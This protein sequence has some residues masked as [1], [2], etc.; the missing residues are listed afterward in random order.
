MTSAARTR[1]RAIT[2]GVI[3]LALLPCVLS[4]V[5]WKLVPIGTGGIDLPPG[6]RL[7]DRSRL[8]FGMLDGATGMD[9]RGD[10][11]ALGRL[12]AALRAD[13]QAEPGGDPISFIATAPD[14]PAW[15][16]ADLDD[17]PE[18]HGWTE[19]Q[20]YRSAWID[21]SSGRAVLEWGGW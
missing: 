21:P 10:P 5:A 12:R 4:V 19:G 8:S 17:W 18:R 9:L 1:R 13:W 7:A 15:W 20:N 6:L 3:L 2:A 16:P 14:R 11:A